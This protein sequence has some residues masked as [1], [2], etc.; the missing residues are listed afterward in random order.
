MTAGYFFMNQNFKQD[1]HWNRF[2]VS[3]TTDA[4]LIDVAGFTDNG[5]LGV[6]QG[7]GWNGTNRNYD[8]EY[9]A[10]APFLAGS[11]ALDN[12]LTL[13]ASVRFD[14]MKQSGTRT[15]GAGGPFD[16]DGDGTIDPPEADVS[17]NTGIGGVANFEVDNTAFSIGA[18]YLLNDSLSFFG[19]YSEGGSFNGERQ[20]FNALDAGGGLLPGGEATYF[21]ETKQFEAGLKWSESGDVI[22]GNLD[23]YVTYF[24]AETEEDNFNITS[25]TA[26]GNTYDTQ[27][28]E[29]ELIYA[30]GGLDVRGF[31]TYTDAEI[32]AST[33]SPANVG[34][35]PRRQ[36]DWVFNVTPSYTVDGL[37]RIGANLNYTGDSF[38]DDDNVLVMPG[39]TIMGVFAD[40]DITDSTTLSLN[41]NNLFDESLFTEAENGRVFDTD[42]DGQN[43]TIVAR[44]ITGRTASATLRF[45]F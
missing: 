10:R 1:W 17:L 2:L 27:G 31:A 39:G 13:D 29:A 15:E 32:T 8:L 3:T 45:R 14:T 18:N 21:D 26:I 24:N 12:G 43:D 42:G 9:Q 38:V 19:R 40:W 7:F 35:A 37:G 6:N 36:A 16:V 34:N 5:I 11:W 4:A 41:V 30:Y 28:I 23:L 44:S 25:Q 20:L 22:P 33:T